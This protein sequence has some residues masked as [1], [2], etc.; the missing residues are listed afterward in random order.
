MAIYDTGG[1]YR[2][3]ADHPFVQTVLRIER[4]DLARRVSG[5]RDFTVR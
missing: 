5:L 3:I 2:F 1:P 4:D